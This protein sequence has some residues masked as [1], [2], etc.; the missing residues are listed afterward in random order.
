MKR[1]VENLLFTLALLVSLIIAMPFLLVVAILRL[2]DWILVKA[3]LKEARAKEEKLPPHEFFR[4]YNI[5]P[6]PF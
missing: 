6:W 4:R 1:M 5:P 3:R 2:A